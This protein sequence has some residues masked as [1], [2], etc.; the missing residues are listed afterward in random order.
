MWAAGVCFAS[1]SAHAAS[2]VDDLVAVSKE[3]QQMRESEVLLEE[4]TERLRRVEPFVLL[5]SG[6]V[7]SSVLAAVAK[8]ASLQF[9]LL[10]ADSALVPRRQLQKARNIADRLH[11]ALH[12]LPN[13]A[14]SEPLFRANPPERCYFFRRHIC[15]L[16]KSLADRLGY[17]SIVDGTNRD[18]LND[19]RPGMKASYEAGVVHPLLDAGVSKKQI[20]SL[21]AFLNLPNA[22]DYPEACLASR[23][24]TGVRI[25][26]GLLRRVEEAEEYLL[27][28]GF[29]GC[30]VRCHGDLARIELRTAGDIRRI[31]GR[32][33]Q[34]ITTKLRQIGFRFV[35]LDLQGYRPAGSHKD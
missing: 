35:T 5:F 27:S 34:L 14:L 4:L 2:K 6:G 23:F 16:A 19:F 10:F 1:S 31:T 12:I 20:R 13:P 24:V 7:D 17:A 15:R 28:L 26:E 32:I 33:R 22:D 29:V 11:I 3:E 9:A 21:A 18:D 25:D 30:R 8:R